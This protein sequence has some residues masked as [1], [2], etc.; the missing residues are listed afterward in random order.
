MSS[1]GVV[2]LGPQEGQG[3]VDALGLAAPALG[4]DL[5]AVLEVGLA[6]ADDVL[7]EDRSWWSRVWE[8]SERLGHCGPMR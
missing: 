3:Q 7:V 4:A 8:L 2:S 1:L 5:A 6:V